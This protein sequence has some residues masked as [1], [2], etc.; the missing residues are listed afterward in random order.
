MEVWYI[1]THALHHLIVV[2]YVKINCTEFSSII[3]Y[4]CT[5]QHMYI[6]HMVHLLFS[7]TVYRAHN[8]LKPLYGMIHLH[9]HWSCKLSK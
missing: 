8:R 9:G 3:L 1:D 5:Y 6:N 2:D 4:E 7:S